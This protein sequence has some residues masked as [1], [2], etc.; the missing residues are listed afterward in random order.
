MELGHAPVVEELTA[1][2]GVT[3]VR[4]PAIGFVHVGHSGGDAAFRHYSVGFSQ[5]RFGDYRYTRACG[6]AFNRRT[7]ARSARANDQD[8]MFMGFILRLVRHNIL[9]S[10]IMP[11]ETMR[12]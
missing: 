9:K 4:S 11:L 6:Q 5:Q 8:I 2:H 12:T 1:A 7:Q 3:K 10:L